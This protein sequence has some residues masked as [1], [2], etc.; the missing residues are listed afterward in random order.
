MELAAHRGASIGL[1]GGMSAE[2]TVPL[3]CPAAFQSGACSEV[4]Q[5]DKRVRLHCQPT[6]IGSNLYAMK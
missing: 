3:L 5:I 4:E 1:C 6:K 2:L